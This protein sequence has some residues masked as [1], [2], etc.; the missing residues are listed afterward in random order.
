LQGE[1]HGKW[2]AVIVGSIAYCP[3]FRGK[4]VAV[5]F[6]M[7]VF[8]KAVEW[9]MLIELSLSFGALALPPPLSLPLCDYKWTLSSCL[10]HNEALSQALL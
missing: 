2:E 9:S 8:R 10:R 3:H 7:T 5:V 4:E 6:L 1:E